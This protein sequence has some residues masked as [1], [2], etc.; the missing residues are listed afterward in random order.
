MTSRNNAGPPSAKG[1]TRPALEVADIV[2]K[3]G[4]AL[5]R[6]NAVTYSQK[7]ILMD[8]EFCRTLAQGGH[9]S[10]CDTCD[11]LEIS[12]NSCRNRHCPKCQA[13]N[14]AQWLE[15]R[16]AELLPVG[17]FHNVFTL[18][19]E[20]NALILYNKKAMLNIL[21][22]AAKDTLNDF[23]K[24]PRYQLQGQLGVT[25]V[26]HTWD[27]KLNPHYHLHC[28]IPGGVYDKT[29]E[30]WIPAK[31]DYLFPVKA[32][33]RVFRGKYVSLVRKAYNKGN[34]KFGGK[35]ETLSRKESFAGLL[36]TVMEKE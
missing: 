15:A 4:A 23:A 2:R 35:I 17:Y 33:S 26:L 25:A 10:K 8:I 24:N 7:K 18:P 1:P 21:F 36:S 12:Y 16:E 34:L 19:H 32:V 27:R 9:S 14:K 22:K 31:N 29:G 11:H 3:Y 28:V 13:L 5:V 20:F 30:R 6:D